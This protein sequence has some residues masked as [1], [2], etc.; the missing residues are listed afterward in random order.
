MDTV[1]SGTGAHHTLTG[2]GFH[3]LV[4]NVGWVDAFEGA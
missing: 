1:R 4:R 3:L 2:F